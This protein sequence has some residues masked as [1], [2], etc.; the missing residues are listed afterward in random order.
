MPSYRTLL[1]AILTL[2]VISCSGGGGD[3]AQ[4]GACGAVT[5]ILN[6]DTCRNT[7]SIVRLEIT[8]DRGEVST[9]TGTF[10]SQTSILTAAHCLLGAAL[11]FSSPTSISILFNDRSTSADS[12]LVPRLYV[13]SEVLGGPDGAFDVAIVKVD[14][15]FMP[16]AGA[17]PQP[18]LRSRSPAAGETVTITGFGITEDGTL[19]LDKVRAAEVSLTGTDQVNRYVAIPTTEN[20]GVCRGDSGSPLLARSTTGEF[21]IIAVTSFGTEFI[22]GAQCGFGTTSY[23]APLDNVGN[24]A[25]LDTYA[26]DAPRV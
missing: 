19:S 14:E 10:I 7:R 22:P 4:A 16:Q 5:K 1:I 23:F 13:I 24:S 6:G 15:R 12:W 8:N 9:C 3:S 25:F 18:L 20:V 17:V 2:P 11:P 21:G 26:P